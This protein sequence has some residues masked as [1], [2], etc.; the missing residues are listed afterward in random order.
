MGGGCLLPRLFPGLGTSASAL[1]NRACGVSRRS[2]GYRAGVHYPVR[3]Q[4]GEV[5]LG[6][7]R[8]ARDGWGGTQSCCSTCAWHMVRAVGML[9]EGR[10]EGRSDFLWPP[11]THLGLRSPQQLPPASLHHR[12]SQAGPLPLEH[13]PAPTF[14]PAVPPTSC[15]SA[16]AP[17]GPAPLVGE[18]CR[19]GPRP[20]PHV[21]LCFR[22]LACS[23]DGE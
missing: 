9:S 20:G 4:S 11:A 7:S 19:R 3:G 1:E 8:W 22:P 12:L 5:S 10:K 15:P 2:E 18:I 17:T 21:E 14:A 16:A 13:P 6:R 23:S